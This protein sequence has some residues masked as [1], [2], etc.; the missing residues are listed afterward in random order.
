MV[1]FYYDATEI[2]NSGEIPWYTLTINTKK[3]GFVSLVSAST[4][5]QDQDKKYV[6]YESRNVDTRPGVSLGVQ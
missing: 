4:A 2:L 5:T 3:Q 6:K 1:V